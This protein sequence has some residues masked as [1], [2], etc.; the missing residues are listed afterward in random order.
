MPT[1]VNITGPGKNNVKVKI[2]IGADLL[3]SGIEF[4]LARWYPDR[5]KQFFI[6]AAEN[7]I[8]PKDTF[9]E[10]TKISQFDEIAVGYLWRGY[11]LLMLGNY[12]EAC[13]LLMQVP[14][15]F[16][17]FKLTGC[18]VWQVYEPNLVK[19]L[20]PLCK[21]KL[22]HA[23]ENMEKARKGL[24]DYIKS[25]REPKFKL[26]ALLYY[27]HLREM[28]PDVYADGGGGRTTAA[29]TPEP[30]PVAGL[31]PEEVEG[32]GA[33]VV[34]DPT[35]Y[36]EIFGTPKELVQFVQKVGKLSDYRLLSNLLDYYNMENTPGMGPVELEKECVRLLEQT[37]DEW[38]REKTES[39]LD[40]ARE[41]QQE[42]GENI[43]L[44]LDPDI[45]LNGYEN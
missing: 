41:S 18:E 29:M 4:N 37:D 21:Y 7:C 35:G 6:W 14:I 17:K 1:Q 16:N 25:F 19:A 23:P 42:G 31:S 10:W 39:L 43:V 8:I 3:K 45:R 32:K 12:S 33:V 15:Y 36:L 5:A 28:F 13:E 24:E 2:G 38:L 9:D 20:L 30:S 40:V 22:N 26:E 44:Y 27:Y 11:A 34:Y